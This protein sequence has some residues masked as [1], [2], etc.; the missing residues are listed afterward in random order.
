MKLKAVRNSSLVAV[1][2]VAHSFVSAVVV[3]GH[4]L[5]LVELQELDRCFL[6]AIGLVHHIEMMVLRSFLP[7]VA[8]RSFVELEVQR[9]PQP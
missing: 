7:V 4:S 8:N 6:T 1:E 9:E 2:R 3:V 5:F